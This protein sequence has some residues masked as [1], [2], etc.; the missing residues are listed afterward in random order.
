M[1]LIM[2][3][4]AAILIV[5][6]AQ[7]LWTRRPLPSL[8][9]TA[10]DWGA[11]TSSDPR[12]AVAAMMVCVAREG[13]AVNEDKREQMIGL[14]TDTMGLTPDVARTCLKGGEQLSR[15]LQGSLNSRLHQMRG[16]IERN[17]NGQERQDV[18]DMLRAVA[19]SS[20]ERVPS[21]REALGRIAGSLLHG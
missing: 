16:T 5:A 14:L 11:P 7:H 15:R 2:P 10:G 9:Q 12:V 20:A 19:G 13:G 6:I 1:F 4:L 18:V 8:P 3:L 21:I 17:C